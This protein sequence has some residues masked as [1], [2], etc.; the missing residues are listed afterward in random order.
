MKKYLFLGL[1][2]LVLYSCKETAKG[3]TEFYF[4]NPQP[5]NDS[6]LNSIPSKFIGEYSNG[7]NEVLIVS[8]AAI[9]KQFNAVYPKAMIDSLGTFKNGK[10]KAN[11]THEIFDAKIIGDS[12]YISGILGDTIFKFSPTQKAKRINGDLVISHKDSLFWKTNIITL[13]KD[14]LKIK[15]LSDREDYSQIKPLVK[16]IKINEDTTVVRINPTRREFGRILKIKK[17]GWE[18]GYKKVK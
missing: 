15:F 11:D 5:I 12:V 2:G 8:Q 1:I 14:S 17:F 16:S 7:E 4:D 6:E 3:E 10:I 13:R 9:Y 18:Q